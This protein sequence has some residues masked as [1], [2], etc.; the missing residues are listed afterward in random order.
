MEKWIYWLEEVDASFNDIVGKKCAN[1][2]ELTKAGFRVP[3]G[4]ALGLAAYDRF[5]KETGVM[6]RIKEFL[7]DFKADPNNP[8]DTIKFEEAS[9]EIRRMVE[10]T[11]MPK[12]MEEVIKEYYEKLCEK[13]GLK[14]TAV[15]TRSAGPVSH[16]GQYETYLNVKGADQVVLNVKRV[17]S[18]TFNARS[19]IARARLNLPLEYDPIGV[20]VLTMVNAKCAGVMF[21][22]DP[23]NGD[24]SKVVIEGSWGYGEAVVSGSVNPDRFKVD[25]VT[26]E[27]EERRISDKDKWYVFDES[28]HKMVYAPVPEEM[29]RVPCLTDEEI[30]ELVKVAK[31]VER[32]F[33]CPQDIEW[34]IS[35]DYSLPKSIFLVQARPESVWGKKEKQA[36]I[37]K[38]DPFDLVLKRATTPIRITKS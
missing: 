31:E 3:P 15:A 8:G 18:S 20:A 38:K 9:S 35:K 19:L 27:I 34:C 17:W 24:I 1:L 25:K 2:G 16:P 29:S 26:F 14:P 10:E 11:P 36:V 6:E 13:T 4:Y 23:S 28:Q 30:V 7:K 12:D 22:L 37:G 21:T 32:H 33:G 5:M